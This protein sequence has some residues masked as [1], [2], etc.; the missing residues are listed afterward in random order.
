MYKS[1][2]NLLKSIF[3]KARR[4]KTK[5]TTTSKNTG[6]SLQELIYIEYK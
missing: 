3:E 1:P 2:I 5:N 4:G 6:L